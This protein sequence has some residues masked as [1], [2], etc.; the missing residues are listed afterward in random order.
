MLRHP[1]RYKICNSSFEAI[2]VK[3][4]CKKSRAAENTEAGALNIFCYFR[5]L[6]QSEPDTI[7]LSHEDSHSGRAWRI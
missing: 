1:S 4:G 7:S 5:Q 6:A 2:R 3:V